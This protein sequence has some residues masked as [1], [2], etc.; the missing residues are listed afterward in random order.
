MLEPNLIIIFINISM[1]ILTCRY[2][3]VNKENQY[4]EVAIRPSGAYVT[5]YMRDCSHYEMRENN[6]HLSSGFP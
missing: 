6:R 4:L 3:C 2:I 1:V 5:I